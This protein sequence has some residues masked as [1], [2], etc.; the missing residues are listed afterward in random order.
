M[1]H[2]TLNLFH[3]AYINSRRYDKTIADVYEWIC[4][5][6]MRLDYTPHSHGSDG[7]H[8]ALAKINRDYS[9][10]LFSWWQF[11]IE[12]CK[13]NHPDKSWKDISSNEL[14]EHRWEC[15]IS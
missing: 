13:S 14:H 5:E 6:R 1:S 8:N 9:E 15:K 10:L 2:I 7:G 12:W 4:E 3:P 11:V